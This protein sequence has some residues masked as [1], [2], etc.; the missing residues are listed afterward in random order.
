MSCLAEFERGRRI[1]KLFIQES[2][3]FSKQG[4]YCLS[5]Y[6][7]GMPLEVV[8][9]DYIPCLWEE[10]FFTKVK[11]TEDKGHELWVS[12]LEKAW[13]KVHG[14]YQRS[15]F[16][17]AHETMRDLTGAPGWQ[18]VIKDEYNMFNKIWSATE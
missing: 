13:S 8:V 6:K 3:S 18:F 1:E 15:A 2:R 10:P 12:L 4:V 9:D 11:F 14:S 7:N 16:G 5:F 17:L